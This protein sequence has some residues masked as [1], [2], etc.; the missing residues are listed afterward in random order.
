MTRIK[1][2]SS[3]KKRK[4]KILRIN[5]GFQTSARKLFR[6][7]KQ[8]QIRTKTASYKDRKRRKRLFRNLWVHRINSAVRLY[9]LNFNQFIHL[10]KKTKIQLNRKIISQ[11]II[12]DPESFLYELK[13]YLPA[14]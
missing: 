13:S 11:L 3:S 14:I 2:G 7:A 12:Y 8:K 10:C 6:I 5:R 1:R 4:I 9:G